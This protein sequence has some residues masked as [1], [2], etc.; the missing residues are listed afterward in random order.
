[1]TVSVSAR[2]HEVDLAVED[3]G[4][5]RQAAGA[6]DRVDRAGERLVEQRRRRR[7]L[8]DRGAAG[9]LFS[10]SSFSEQMLPRWRWSIS[11]AFGSVTESDL[12]L[13]SPGAGPQVELEAGLPARRGCLAAAELADRHLRLEGEGAQLTAWK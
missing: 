9:A 1:M 4:Q 5:A 2:G 12:M 6:R 11:K 3:E 8:A 10:A 13:A 7:R